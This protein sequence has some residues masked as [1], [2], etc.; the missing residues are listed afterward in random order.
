MHT[1]LAETQKA[2]DAWGTSESVESVEG[3]HTIGMRLESEPRL[4]SFD[5][6]LEQCA[7][8]QQLTI[9]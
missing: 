3:T 5:K 6:E 7:E 8:F 1:Y 2:K 4:W 9:M